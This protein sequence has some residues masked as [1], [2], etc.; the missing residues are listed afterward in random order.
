M[1]LSLIVLS[2][3]VILLM[4]GAGQRILDQMRLN[5][6]Q[7]ILVLL[8]IIVGIIIPP[9]YLSKYFCF[10]IGGFLIPLIICLYMLFSA[11]VSRDL[12]RA[13]IGVILVAGIIYALE[14]I[15]PAETPED[16]VIDPMYIYG[17]VAGIIA[18]S[19]GRSRRNAFICS[20]LGISLA[21]TIQFIINM[22]KGTPTVLGLGVGGAFGTIIISTIISVGLCE[23]LGRAFETA[24]KD[25]EHKVFNFETH[26]YDSEKNGK[27]NKNRT[28]AIVVE[29]DDGE[30]L[31]SST[32]NKYE[33]T[34][35]NQKSSAVQ[36]GLRANGNNKSNKSNKGHKIV[37]IFLFIICAGL[38]FLPTELE[39]KLS[40]NAETQ[41]NYYTI[42]DYEN[43]EEVIFLKG[44]HVNLDDEYLSSDNKLYRIVE[45]DNKNKTGKAEFI[46]N[47]K[48]PEYDV[49]RKKTSLAAS[50]G[51]DKKVGVYHTHNDESY[52]IGDGYDSVYG[53]GGIHDVGQKFVSNLKS[54]GFDVIYDQSL[55]LPHN[56]GAY[57]RS[58]VTASKILGEKNVAAIFDVHRDS[59]PRSE[60]YTK[61]DGKEMTKIRMVIGSANQNFYENKEFAYAI[62][63]YADK[64]Y[65]GLIKDIYMGKGNYNQQL[66]GRAMLFEFGCE[67]L[68]KELVLRSA[69]P[70]SKTLDVVL[71][72][73]NNASDNSLSDV[74]LKTATG[75]TSKITG[76][77][78]KKSTASISFFWILLAGIAFYFI[79]LGIVC[80]FSKTARHKTARFFKEL[81]PF[82]KK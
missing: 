9:V 5:D 58:Q 4:F 37:S 8:S 81:F 33:R 13:V 25:D 6:K 3:L 53:E 54:L 41:N 67:N 45:V 73:S 60:Y 44:E 26:T 38:I 43:K 30:I 32:S 50:A 47:E 70:L 18:Y 10:S 65:P 74:E 64:V 79:V 46:C 49:Q 7:A 59:V 48:L 23:F 42:Y 71:F 82:R 24:Q 2:G 75:E 57:T 77:A 61:V 51:P 28:R 78:Y 66:T 31:T 63:S 21:E 35:K 72:G 17:V 19:L 56:S 40:A 52:L 14:W 69:E 11:G 39:S 1:S 62:K 20:V 12:L 27:L 36:G 22:A 55:H 29:G 16:I 68:E 76:I 15:M 34:N 80:I